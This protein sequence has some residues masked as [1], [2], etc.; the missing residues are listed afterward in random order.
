MTITQQTINDLHD[1][2]R[3]MC[4]QLEMQI[5]GLKLLMS[6][7]E[8]KHARVRQTMDKLHVMRWADL[9]TQTASELTPA[10]GAAAEQQNSMEA[11]R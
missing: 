6:E 10:E 7:A 11:I 2:C 4:A 5:N 3:R 9:D 8:R 1:R